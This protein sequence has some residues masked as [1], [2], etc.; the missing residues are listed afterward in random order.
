MSLFR[1]FDKV[2]IGFVLNLKSSTVYSQATP[3]EQVQRTQ[4][5][6]KGDG[7]D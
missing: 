5:G 3:V 2:F 7:I 6:D 1:G 4:E